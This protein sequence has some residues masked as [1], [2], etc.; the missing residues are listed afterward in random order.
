MPIKPQT[1]GT[2]VCVAFI[3]FMAFGVAG[4][5]A[6]SP[7]HGGHPTHTS[8]SVVTTTLTATATVIK[9]NMVTSTKTDVVTDLY[10]Q[11][12]GDLVFAQNATLVC[13]IPTT[14]ASSQSSVATEVGL[15][16]III[17]VVGCLGW[18]AAIIYVDYKNAV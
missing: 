1:I 7:A 13:V 3:V 11:L 12:T 8:T 2:A 16:N 6:A 9:T 17:A 5:V 14:S 18:C 10:C 4:A 15:V